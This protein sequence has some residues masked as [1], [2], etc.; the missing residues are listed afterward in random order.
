[1]SGFGVLVVLV[2]AIVFILISILVGRLDGIRGNTSAVVRP[3]LVLVVEGISLV[4]ATTAVLLAKAAE[5]L[6]S[7]E[8]IGL[9]SVPSGFSG[10]YGVMAILILLCGG[11][12][13]FTHCI[14]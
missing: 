2:I 8:H 9:A 6:I 10:L 7:T 5:Y 14:R 12:L 11:L 3:L 1:M 13:S 4:Y